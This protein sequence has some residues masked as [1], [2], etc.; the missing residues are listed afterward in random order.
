MDILVDIVG[1][2]GLYKINKNGDVWS[3]R[4]N[5]FLKQNYNNYGY[6][7][8]GLG[9]NNKPLVHRLLA[10]NFIPNPDN[11]DFIDHIDLNSTNNTLENL[12]W[13]TKSTNQQNTTRHKDNTSGFKHIDTRRNKNRNGSISIYWRIRINN[14]NFKCSLQYSKNKYTLEEVVEFR[15]KIYIDNNIQKYD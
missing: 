2:E 13:A 1:Y 6:L 3:C 15:N 5:I 7:V 4:S 9:R 11:L 12:R 8:V 14:E 10:I